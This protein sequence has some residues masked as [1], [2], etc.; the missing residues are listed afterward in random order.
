[1]RAAKGDLRNR[2][3][4]ARDQLGDAY[5]ASC[6]QKLCDYL[7]VF[8]DVRGK[9]VS[10]FLPIQ[11]EID[12]QPLMKA[13]EVKG[14][15][16]CLPVVLDKTTIEFRAWADGEALVDAG[17]GTKGPAKEA[18]PLLPDVMIVPLAAFDAYG[19]RIGYGAGYYD[20]AIARLREAGKSP[21]TVGLGFALQEVALVPQNAHDIALDAILTHEGVI[22]PEPRP[23]T[24]LK[25]K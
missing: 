1:M 15:R 13:L 20:R 12:A 14:A 22:M 21:K 3:L 25:G 4:M 11:S 23:H 24:T 9:V 18:A 6:A 16:L 10:G 7:D 2:V 17:F 8:D 5:R 19:G